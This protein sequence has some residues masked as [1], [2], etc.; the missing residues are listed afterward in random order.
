MAGRVTGNRAGGGVESGRAARTSGRLLAVLL[1]ASVAATGLAVVTTGAAAAQP[2]PSAPPPPPGPA[3]HRDVGVLFRVNFDFGGDEIAEVAFSDGSSARLMAGTGFSASAGVFYHP[4]RP[5]AVELTLGVKFDGVDASNGSIEFVR[6]PIDLVVSAAAGRLRFGAGP[7]LHL[8]PSIDCD[9]GLCGAQTTIALHNAIGGLVQLG[10]GFPHGDRGWDLGLRYTRIQYSLDGFEP[11]DAARSGFSPAAGCRPSQDAAE[12][13]APVAL[14]GPSPGR[15]RCV[16]DRSR[17][18][19]QRSS[20]TSRATRVATDSATFAGL[21]ASSSRSHE[22]LDVKRS[23]TG[24]DVWQ[25]MSCSR[26]SRS[27]SLRSFQPA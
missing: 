15:G 22:N 20:V 7:T 2:A 18:R 4:A 13:D 23:S 3:K 27:S 17:N 8:A 12:A 21:R 19:H 11:L 9:S 16:L 10:F 25:A 5:W 26:S 24:V 14:V 6:F 1:A